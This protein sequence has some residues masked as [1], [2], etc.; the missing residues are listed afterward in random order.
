M[1]EPTLDDWKRCV[2]EVHMF[3]R[4]GVD[5]HGHC[6]LCGVLRQERDHHEWCP[7]RGVRKLIGYITF[8]DLARIYPHV[9]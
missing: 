2:W 4:D 3:I 5:V 7:Y 9:E 8:D 6:E 1:T